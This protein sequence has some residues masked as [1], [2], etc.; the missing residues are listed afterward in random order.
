[1]TTHRVGDLPFVWGRAKPEEALREMEGRRR[2]DRG[3]TETYRG[4]LPARPGNT[5][6]RLTRQ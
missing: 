5:G 6:N 2:P 1:M 3:V 4:F